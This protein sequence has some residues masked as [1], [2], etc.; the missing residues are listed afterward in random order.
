LDPVKEKE[1][2]ANGEVA[3]SP[4][5]VSFRYLFG[6]DYRYNDGHGPTSGADRSKDYLPFLKRSMNDFFAEPAGPEGGASGICL[7]AAAWAG[8]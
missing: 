4:Q 7:W 3:V 1:Y 6:D 5:V 8:V 2:P